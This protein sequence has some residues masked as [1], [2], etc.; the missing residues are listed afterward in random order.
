[1]FDIVKIGGDIQLELKQMKVTIP[2]N[3]SLENA[4]KGAFL[5]LQ[6]VVDKNKQPALQVCTKESVQEALLDMVVQ[7]LDPLKDQCYFLVY[8]TQLACQRSYHGDQA[9]S[10]RVN[11]KVVDITSSVVYRGDTFKFSVINGKKVI[12]E[13][14]Q[15]LEGME[16]GEIVGAYAIAMGEDD[17]P[18]YTDIMSAAEIRQ[19]WAQSKAQI[20]LTNGA[21]KPESVQGKF[22][23]KMYSKTV[24][25][26]LCKKIIN[27]S[28]DSMLLQAYGRTEESY[29]NGEVID[30]KASSR[31]AT[32]PIDFEPQKQIQAP[33]EPMASREQ[34]DIIVSLGKAKNMTSKQILDDISKMIGRNVEKVS[35]ISAAEAEKYIVMMTPAAKEDPPADDDTPPWGD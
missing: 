8:G 7:G 1:M 25:K 3:Y 29:D 13:H 11:P 16:N 21:V 2:Q 24:I 35:H 6:Q 22:P 27:T 12:T 31:N 32:K 23:V 18:L 14:T 30:I 28:D 26:R 34:F 4:L 9:I 19:S 10:M 17:K 5:K 33:T 20:F 15:T